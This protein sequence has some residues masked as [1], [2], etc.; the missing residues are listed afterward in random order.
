MVLEARLK[1][2]P[3][4]WHWATSCD[5]DLEGR[6]AD[7]TLCNPCIIFPLLMLQLGSNIHLAFDVLG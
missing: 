2:A 7:D 4:R 6:Q 1:S 3:R 5:S